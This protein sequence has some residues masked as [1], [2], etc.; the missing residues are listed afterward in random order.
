MVKDNIFRQAKILLDTK[1]G[2]EMTEDELQLINTALIPLVVKTNGI[3]PENM[4]IREG[5]E[6]L[7]KIWDEANVA[8]SRGTVVVN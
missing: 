7:A 2:P 1:K 3:F 4:T 8:G 6:E 5:L